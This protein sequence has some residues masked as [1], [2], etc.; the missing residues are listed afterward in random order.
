MAKKMSNILDLMGA[1]NHTWAAK[2]YAFDTRLQS[3]RHLCAVV[4]A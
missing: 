3:R 4:M 2:E 1:C